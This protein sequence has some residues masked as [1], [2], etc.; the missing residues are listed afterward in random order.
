M[1][2]FGVAA[3]VILVF[4]E[5]LYTE[6][7]TDRTAIAC[8]ATDIAAV[9]GTV[10]L[11]KV[12]GTEIPVPAAESETVPVYAEVPESESC[13]ESRT[14]TEDETES[15]SEKILGSGTAAEQ[16]TSAESE[17]T[18]EQETESESE[19]V[20]ESA[21]AAESE[22]SA[23]SETM[24]PAEG[25]ELLQEQMTQISLD[26][27]PAETQ[28]EKEMPE[29]TEK[30]E[31]PGGSAASEKADNTEPESGGLEQ[32]AADLEPQTQMSTEGLKEPVQET[33]AESLTE[34]SDPKAEATE[35][36]TGE[37][38]EERGRKKKKKEKKEKKEKKQTEKRYDVVG[39]AGAWY[40]DEAGHLWVRPGSSLYLETKAGSVCTGEQSF[41][42]LQED[43]MIRFQVQ[44]ADGSDGVP[45]TCQEQY[46]IDGEAPPADITL[47]GKVSGGITYVPDTAK[48]E[49]TVAPDGRSG[50]KSSAYLVLNCDSGGRLLCDP[51]KEEWISCRT[52]H[53]V[54]IEQEG[55]YQ[56][57]VRT[58]DNVGNVHFSKSGIVCVDRTA[59]KITIGGVQDQTANSGK[60]KVKIK[61][62]DAHYKPGSLQIEFAGINHGKF[63]A[64][65]EK[66]ETDRGAAVRYFDFPVQKSYDDI[67]R[68]SVTAEDMAGNKAEEM[69]E[70][71]VNR[72]G[73]VYELSE[74]TREKLGQYFLSKAEPIT[75][76]ETNID[77]VGESD[78]YCRRDGELELLRRGVDYSVAMTGT[79]DSWKRY[80]YTVPAGY[81]QKEG[82]YELLLTSKDSADN[83]SD[84]G[85]QKK[86]VAFVLDWTAPDCTVTG[87]EAEQ[88]YDAKCVTACVT[89]YDNTGIRRMKVYRDSTVILERE[90]AGK[91]D[92]TV[93]ITLDQAEDWQTLRVWLEDMAGNSYWSQK[94]PVFVGK[95]TDEAPR[96]RKDRRSADAA[97]KSTARVMK[98]Q[99][100]GADGAKA[101]RIAGTG[102]NGGTLLLAFGLLMFAATA[103]SFAIN[104]SGRKK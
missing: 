55:M 52:E 4:A 75:F 92:E 19:K 49:I 1:L 47:S 38:T 67:Y 81:F 86:Q 61:G 36:Q 30:T 10:V 27:A 76:Y 16:E 82:V 58:E 104:G 78:I 103:A 94:I 74:E 77:Y 5:E 59:P 8:G 34:V 29:G 35:A 20:P 23:E 22:T 13:A 41:Q 50:L 80:C 97:L 40:R 12:R 62:N 63:P 28:T 54:Q 83:V 42:N 60:V 46:A 44:S 21:A 14:E 73:S 6:C 95:K 2:A 91:E 3:A 98:E 48:A 53:T 90:E 25:A 99:S 39:D 37:T 96:Y 69:I 71:S 93:K 45:E 18:A 33:A 26:A 15:E 24:P 102:Q 32:T 79:K 85:I 31:K 9:L 56:I 88:G 100:L 57:F 84:T 64:V 51:Q 43:G 65:S 72:Y 17:T 68:L 11:E 66:K 89:P 7:Y 87:I 70:F 101:G